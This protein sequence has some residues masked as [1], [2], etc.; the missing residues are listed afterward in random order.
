MTTVNDIFE[1]LNSIAPVSTQEG[2]DNS[3]FIIGN[4]E[5]LVD[6]VI[7]ALDATSEVIDEAEVCNA[8]LIVTHHPVIF[9]AFKKVFPSDPTGKKI[10]SLCRNNIS[11]ISMHTNLDKAAGGVNDVLI[12][13]L[14]VSEVDPADGDSPFMR[15]G[16]LNEPMEL[17]DYLA[18]CSTALNA[19]GLR[20]HDAGK[21]VHKIACI[22]GAGDFG[23]ADAFAKG[24]DTFITGD[25]KH[26]V[27]LE[28]AEYGINLIDAGHFCT[29]NPVMSYLKEILSAEFAS[30][31]FET[32]HT[33]VQITKYYMQGHNNG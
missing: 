9:N 20:Y 13:A 8:Q 18:F 19:N 16:S 29:E 12:R 26:H 30:V 32:A 31:D 25:I 24:C 21:M 3:G 22:G 17:A 23:I 11:V 6:K 14:G 1:Y 27:F 4:P 7:L 2:F 10:Y 5:G 15:T 33:N 28:A